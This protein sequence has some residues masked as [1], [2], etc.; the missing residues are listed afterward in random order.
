MAHI[1]GPTQDASTS[2]SRA[3]WWWRWR[4]SGSRTWNLMQTATETCLPYENITV[5]RAMQVG[6]LQLLNERGKVYITRM[7]GLSHLASFLIEC[8]R[9]LTFMKKEGK[10]FTENAKLR[11]LF[12]RVQHPQLHD[13][14]K[15][16]V[17]VTTAVLKRRGEYK[18]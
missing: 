12:K 3:T 18:P 6:A 13:T 1:S 9:C 15:V 8:R 16:E 11:E 14:I 17:A 7:K 5:E 2:Y 4:S 10:E